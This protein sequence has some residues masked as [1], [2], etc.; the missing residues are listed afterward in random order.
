MLAAVGFR[1]GMKTRTLLLLSVGT[2]L[3][4]LVAGGVLLLQLSNEQQSIEPTPLGDAA[5]VGDATVTVLAVADDPTGAGLVTLDVELGGVDDL[6]GL[7]SFRLVVRGES[8]APVTTRADGRCRSIEIEPR[9][10]LLQFGA[11]LD[12]GA[13][14]L[15][16]RRGDQQA[17]WTVAAPAAG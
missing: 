2:A 3:A 8:F 14:V 11:D 7:D 6:D 15:V 4:I 1:P 17:N 10:C 9:R 5:T 12:G 13:G 16:M